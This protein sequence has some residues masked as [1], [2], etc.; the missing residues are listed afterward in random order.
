MSS[1]V[2]HGM[3]MR[4]S[5]TGNSN[6]RLEVMSYELWAQDTPSPPLGDFPCFR[7]REDL[8]LFY[9]LVCRLLVN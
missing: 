6:L 8:A 3:T 9:Q 2:K 5:G 1:R 7:G 4:R